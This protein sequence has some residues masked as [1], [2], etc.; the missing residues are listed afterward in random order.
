MG[1][2]D[3]TRPPWRQSMKYSALL[4]PA[5]ISACKANHPPAAQAAPPSSSS[6][7]SAR[8]IMTPAGS[9]WTLPGGDYAATRFSSLTQITPANAAQLKVASTF[10]T[11]VLHGH[12]GNP[13]V[14]KNTM[15]IVT[16]W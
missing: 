15:Y 11:G 7:S 5:V 8:A 4:L 12:E 1:Y 16:P 2:A 3:G 14:V 6:S 13:L 10:S 9:E